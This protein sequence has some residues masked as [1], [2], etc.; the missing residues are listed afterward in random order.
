[1]ISPHT[2]P[3]TWVVV[4]MVVDTLEKAR[5]VLHPRLWS[6]VSII[7]VNTAC[8]TI[9]AR[10]RV[11]SIDPTD[12]TA[13]GFCVRM[14]GWGPTERSFLECFDVATLPDSLT[15]LLVGKPVKEDA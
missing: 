1:M 8:S 9:G 2:P 11:A 5:R 4:V 10:F 12:L 14:E 15:S 13:C 7:N 3:G 6:R